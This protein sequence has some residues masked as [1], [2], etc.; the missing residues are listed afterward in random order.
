MTFGSRSLMVIYPEHG[1]GV[2]VLT[3]SERGFPLAYDVAARAIGGK[4]SLR[5]F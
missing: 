3:N 4:D 1:I 2:V 5:D